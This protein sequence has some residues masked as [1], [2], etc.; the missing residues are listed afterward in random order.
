MGLITTIDQL[1]SAPS[2]LDGTE[3]TLAQT[4]TGE[5]IQVTMQQVA[6]L[7]ASI[8]GVASVNGF[9]GVVTIDAGDIGAVPAV[10]PAQPSSIDGD[11][12]IVTQKGSTY[13]SVTAQQ[14]ANLAGGAVSSV[15]TQ[16]GAVVLGAGDVGAMPGVGYAG[17]QPSGLDGTELLVVQKGSAYVQVTTQQIA[18]LT[19]GTGGGS[20]QG[21][22][23]IAVMG[24]SILPSLSGGCSPLTVYA[25]SANRP[26]IAALQ[27]DPTTTEYAQFSLPMPKKWDEGTITAKFIWAHPATATNFGVVWGLQAV[28]VSD[29]DTIDVTYGTAQ[30]VADTGGTTND[31]YTT[32]ETSAITVA[33]TPQAE[34]VVYFR[35]Y[36]DAVA[37]GNT[38]AVDAYLLGV[39]VYITTN[40][41]TDA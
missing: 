39:V 5:T 18:D 31:L 25:T 24:G 1:P 41:D 7:A 15:N 9:T 13:V 38:L 12:V 34:D 27:F 21:K 20:T 23:S 28:A 32:A 26:D 40:A 19:P 3:V 11:E 29:D 4:T 8:S 17:G 10:V 36:R 2:A 14:I 16:T 30:T 35:V 37:G 22:H 33:G 6:D